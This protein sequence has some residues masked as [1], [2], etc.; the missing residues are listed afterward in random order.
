[1]KDIINSLSKTF[2]ALV[3]SKRA[4]AVFAS[5]V[6]IVAK[7]FWPDK[8]ESIYAAIAMLA[9]WVLGESFRPAIAKTPADL[10]K[11][12]TDSIDRYY[13]T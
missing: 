7:E 9:A 8:A 3:H 6:M 2:L 10:K 5:M 13:S 4:W 1:M 11:P 12:T